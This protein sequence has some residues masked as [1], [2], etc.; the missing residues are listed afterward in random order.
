MGGGEGSI[1][2]ASGRARVEIVVERGK[3]EFVPT[4][5]GK[6]DFRGARYK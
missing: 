2:P 3:S 4:V 5:K 1:T 6:V